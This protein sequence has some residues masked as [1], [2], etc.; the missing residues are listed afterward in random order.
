MRIATT[1]VAQ[2]VR[3]LD[4]ANLDTTCA[5]CTDF[6]Q[7]ANRQWLET[8][9]IPDDRTNWGTF[10]IIDSRNERSRSV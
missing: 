4:R 2:R 3:P 9:Q 1:A 10:A 5:P 6:Y 8:T 7:F